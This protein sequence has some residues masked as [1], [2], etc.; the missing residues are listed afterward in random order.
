[1]RSEES[2]EAIVPARRAGRAE[3]KKKGKHG[4]M[5]GQRPKKP[6][7]GEPKATGK[8]GSRAK[9]Q[10]VEPRKQP[11]MRPTSPRENDLIEK[12]VERGNMNRAWKRVKA[13]HGGPGPDGKTVEETEAWLRQNGRELAEAIRTGRYQPQVVKR[14]AI[15]KPGGGTRELGIP[16][17]V[18]RLIQQ[19]MLQVLQPLWDP[20]FHPSSFGFR[21]GRSAH[22]ALESARRH[23]R[24]G[25]RWVVDADLEKFFD[26][27]D[28]AV[29][30]RRVS[31][32]VGDKKVL[33]LIRRYLK[34]GAMVGD[35]CVERKEGTPQGGPL[36]PL[37]ANLLLDDVDWELERRGLVFCRY[38][39]DCNIYVRSERSA[40]RAMET[41]KK[42]TGALKLKVNETKSATAPATSRKFLGYRLWWSKGVPSYR[43]APEAL[44]KFR[45]E[46][47]GLTQRNCG[48]SLSE[49]IRRLSVYLRG[50]RAY[51]SLAETPRVF[52]ELDGWIRRRLRMLMLKQWKTAQRCVQALMGRGSSIESAAGIAGKRRSY[53]TTSG[54]PAFNVFFPKTY[55]QQLGLFPLG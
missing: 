44:A 32:R 27:V 11:V 25:K 54:H 9:R 40:K 22:Q 51:F 8:D 30:M 12:V 41:L 18:D 50:W 26:R 34:A 37:L 15:L 55:F 16:N 42:L 2:A 45:Q 5:S 35:I 53:W 14:V 6:E 36:S 4:A 24:K 49:V 19:A 38:A 48:K 28:H 17:A 21:P 20:S 33:Q 13:N 39:D 46:V 47:R 43:V 23:V 3:P 52:R 7:M 31:R 1:V 29:L 10:G